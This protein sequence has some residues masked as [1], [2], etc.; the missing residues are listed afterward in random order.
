MAIIF[1]EETSKKMIAMLTEGAT[2]GFAK[3]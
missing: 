1:F 2:I 3:K